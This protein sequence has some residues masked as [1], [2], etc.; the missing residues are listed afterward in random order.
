MDRYKTSP[1]GST[2]AERLARWR[3]L[4]AENTYGDWVRE[5]RATGKWNELD[6]AEHMLGFPLRLTDEDEA[7]PQQPEET[8][9]KAVMKAASDQRREAIRR[10]KDEGQHRDN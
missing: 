6:D 3:Q 2:F 4:E 9:F 5:M 8:E 7:Y 10:D 1:D